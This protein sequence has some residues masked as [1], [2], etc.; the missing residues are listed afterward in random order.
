MWGGERG[1]RDSSLLCIDLNIDRL[2]QNRGGTNIN[3]SL[4]EE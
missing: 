4:S 1:P 2:L 3:G